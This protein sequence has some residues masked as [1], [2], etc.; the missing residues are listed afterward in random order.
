MS[1]S[2]INKKRNEYYHKNRDRELSNRRKRDKTYEGFKKNKLTE[3][4]NKTNLILDDKDNLFFHY[5]NTNI[6]EICD[7]ELGNHQQGIKKKCLDHCHHSGYF[8]FVCCNKC[9]SRLGKVD[10][11]KD[12]VHLELYRYFNRQ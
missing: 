5:Y 12:K 3:W 2:L 10:R 1:V 4:K 7:K 6:C 11:I 8:R 9:N